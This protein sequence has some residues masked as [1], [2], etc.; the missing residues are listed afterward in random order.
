MSSDD[1]DTGA[2][3]GGRLRQRPQGFRSFP[4]RLISSGS[5]G[6]STIPELPESNE[7][8]GSASSDELTRL[9][10][11]ITTPSH[12]HSAELRGENVPSNDR[13]MFL[14]GMALS[15]SPV[16]SPSPSD[17]QPFT[18]GL[19]PSTLRRSLPRSRP[20]KKSSLLSNVSSAS[21][22]TTI[23]EPP[24]SPSRRRWDDLRQHFLPHLLS[25]GAP[26]V[27]PPSTPPPAFHIPPRPSTPKQFRM[28]KLGFKQAAEKASEASVDRTMRFEDDILRASRAVRSADSKGQ[29]AVA[30]SFNMSF[31]SSSASLGLSTPTYLPPSR[32]KAT[33]R[34]PSLQST[35]TPHSPS[36]APT[37]YTVISYYAS[38]TP[39]QQRSTITLPHE[40]E[41]LS[42]LL[43]PFMS[44]RSD[45]VVND[46]LQ[47]VEAVE[48]IV[49]TWRAASEVV[50]H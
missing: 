4:R 17:D 42:A 8:P 7:I 50:A 13:N 5:V 1:S 21:D 49:T 2:G 44:V 28:P 36:A 9:P 11:R 27:Q 22:L 33:Q 23:D 41:V 32:G 40:S 3:S 46:Q 29:K 6:Q 38:I 39:R 26:D 31:M 47:A 25:S 43:L 14:E 35:T 37:L 30:T 18:L 24:P 10:T 16:S 15:E 12:S 20:V 48:I 34:P 19:G 45:K